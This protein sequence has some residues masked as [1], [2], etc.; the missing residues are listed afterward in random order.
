MERNTEMLE[1]QKA[2][3]RKEIRGQLRSLPEDEKEQEQPDKPSAKRVI[4][5]IGIALLVNICAAVIVAVL[6]AVL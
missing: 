6:K 1:K 4:R 2:D 5:G 3:L